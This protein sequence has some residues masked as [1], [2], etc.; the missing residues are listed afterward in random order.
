MCLCLLAR[1]EAILVGH[2]LSYVIIWI[3]DFTFNITIP[4]IIYKVILQFR[5]IRSISRW[6]TS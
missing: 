3:L 5:R 4:L 2:T 1:S 6:L